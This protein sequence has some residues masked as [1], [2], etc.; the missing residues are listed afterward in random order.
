MLTHS[1]LHS[2]G[3]SI[4]LSSYNQLQGCRFQVLN[5]FGRM[6]LQFSVFSL[7]FKESICMLVS[8]EE[9]YGP[10]QNL[11]CVRIMYNSVPCRKFQK[12]K[13]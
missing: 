8:A 12:A 11:P 4:E 5:H 6:M 10:G 2:E 13:N 7:Y 9:R 1:S 3:N